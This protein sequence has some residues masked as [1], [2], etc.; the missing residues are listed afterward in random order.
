MGA[1][2]FM[3]DRLRKLVPDLVYCGRDEAASPATGRFRQHEAEEKRFVGEALG[4]SETSPLEIE[5]ARPSK[6]KV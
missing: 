4:I 1:W 2:T 3:S 6:K 5:S